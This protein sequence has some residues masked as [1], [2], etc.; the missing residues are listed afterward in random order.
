VVDRRSDAVTF[1]PAAYREKPRA[2]RTELVDSSAT[3]FRNLATTATASD[4]V[5]ENSRSLIRRSS[6]ARSFRIAS[7]FLVRTSVTARV[8]LIYRVGLAGYGLGSIGKSACRLACCSKAAAADKSPA[9]PRGRPTSCNPT[10]RPSL[11]NPHG[12]EIAGQA[13]KV[14]A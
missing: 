12:T 14:M 3:C 4:V 11:V 8:S 1:P 2:I 10:G 13:V 7:P 5:P 9:S 6:G